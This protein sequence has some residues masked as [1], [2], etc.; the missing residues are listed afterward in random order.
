[1]ASTSNRDGCPDKLHYL[2]LPYLPY[3]FLPGPNYRLIL[4]RK[5]QVPGI[6]LVSLGR[7]Q[8][9]TERAPHMHGLTRDKRGIPVGQKPDTV[10]TQ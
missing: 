4:C 2:T 9:A 3:L 1:M 10:V 8:S 5:L 7:R 6:E